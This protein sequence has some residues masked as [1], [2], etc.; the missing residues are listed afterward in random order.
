MPRCCS[1]KPQ[2]RVGNGGLSFRKRTAMLAV[3]HH[4]DEVNTS[5]AQ[6]CF[7]D[8]FVFTTVTHKA[9]V[10]CAAVTALPN[11]HERD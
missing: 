10:V 2:L 7:Y 8:T 6:H 1:N 3:V 11:A 9:M 5:S 4:R